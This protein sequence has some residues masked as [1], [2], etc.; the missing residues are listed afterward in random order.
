MKQNSFLKGTVS[1]PAHGHI[2]AKLIE[3][4]VASFK[5]AFTRAILGKFRKIFIQQLSSVLIE[6][7]SWDISV[8]FSFKGKLRS[9][10]ILPP[11]EVHGYRISKIV[12]IW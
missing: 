5:S 1:H 6:F 10:N 3:N 9:R 11:T 8:E 2:E 4:V 12:V 7:V